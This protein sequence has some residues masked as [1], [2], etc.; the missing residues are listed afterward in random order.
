MFSALENTWDQ[1]ARRRWTTIGSFTLQALAVS[2][3]L[4]IPLLNVQGPP[5]LQ[6]ITS[7]FFSPP[8]AQAPVTAQNPQRSMHASNMSG[9]HIIAP[10]SIPPEI[11]V[12]HD[13]DVPAAPAIGEFGV[14]GGTNVFPRGVP[15]GFRE[16]ITVAPPPPPVPTHPLRISHWA[17]GNLIY[18]VRPAYPLLAREARIQGAVKLRAI[19]SRTGTIENLTVLDGHAMLVSAAIEAVKQWR[20]RPYLLN[21]EPIEV[22]TEITVNFTLSGS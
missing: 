8:P 14:P 9:V 4:A 17:E 20:Y 10:P 11:A 1:S 16:T 21:G 22:E 19:I 2:L 13:A 12:I 6:W 7:P 3:L 5:R 15:G 18:R